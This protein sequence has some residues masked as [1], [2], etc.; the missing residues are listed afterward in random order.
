M[1]RIAGRQADSAGFQFYRSLLIMLGTGG[2]MVAVV[3]WG[4]L[5][6]KTAFPALGACLG[7]VLGMATGRVARDGGS[8][9]GVAAV[10]GFFLSN[11]SVIA[12]SAMACACALM[13]G[14]EVPGFMRLCRTDREGQRPGG[15]FY[16]TVALEVVTLLI[17]VR[18][19][20]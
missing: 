9:L 17:T 12:A 3:L 8:L 16:L 20:F 5:K 2:V 1:A 14:A 15:Y 10:A 19:F 7:L 18:W 6:A 4:V 11:G 13:V